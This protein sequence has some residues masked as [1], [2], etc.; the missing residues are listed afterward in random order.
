MSTQPSTTTPGAKGRRLDIVFNIHLISDST[1]ETLNAV[2][3]ASCAQFDGIE[4]VEHYYYLMR[5]ERQLQ[6]VL[7]EIDDAPGIVM[8]TIANPELRG[9]LE[10][11]CRSRAIPFVSILDPTLDML[12]EY[13][14]LK[15]TAKIA[16]QHGLTEDYF[17]R[18]EAMNFAMAHDDGQNIDDLNR[19]DVV[20]LGVSRTSKTPTCI[21]LANRGIMAGNIPIVPGVELTEIVAGLT[22]PL[23]VGLRLNPERLVHIR[24]TRLAV[25]Q[26]D[27]SIEYTDLDAIRQEN[28]Y[29]NRLFERFKLPVIDV[30]RR[31]IEETAAKILNLLNEKEDGHVR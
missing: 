31:S 3:T 18:I 28:L 21:Y 12:S 16:A 5:S 13:L 24:Q 7:K 15:K 1:G 29:A 9:K 25:M 6:R 17:H 20:L 8:S 11:H 27:R 2:M 4:P 10:N 26:E 19:A 14:G 30:T 23:V 22:R